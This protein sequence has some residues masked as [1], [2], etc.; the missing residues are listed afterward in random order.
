MNI[1]VIHKS[2]FKKFFPKFKIEQP[3][4]WNKNALAGKF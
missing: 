4:G 3:G 2:L 1:H